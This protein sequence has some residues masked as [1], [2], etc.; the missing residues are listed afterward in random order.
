LAIAPAGFA[1]LSAPGNGAVLL[2]GNF[3]DGFI[4]AFDAGTGAALG[5]LRDPDGEAIQIDGLWALKVGNGGAGG[6][7]NTVYFSAGPFGETHGLFGSLSTAAPGS[8][9]GPAEA[10][11][12]QANLDVVQLDLQ[13]LATDTA[14]GAPVATIRQDTRTLDAASH[15]LLRAEQ[16]F[17]EDSLD[18]TAP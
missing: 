18:D 9:E 11:W 2:V 13:Q 15:A 16:A 12:V 4:N 1:G 14:S 17:G 7:T 8:P 3:G 6:A 5:H 10:Q